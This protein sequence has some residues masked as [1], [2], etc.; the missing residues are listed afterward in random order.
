MIGRYIARR[1]IQAVPTLLGITVLAYTIM[2]LA[3]GDPLL[4]FED[5]RGVT[6]EQLASLRQAYGFDRPLPIQYLDWLSR[7][8]RLDFGRSF[9]THLPARDLIFERMPATL[10]LTLSALAV[11]I[12]VGIPAGVWAAVW[13]GRWPDQLVR[14]VAV[15]GDAVPH[16][17]LGLIALAI[18]AVQLRWLPTGGILTLGADPLDIGD[19]LRHL[20][21]PAV[22]LGTGSLAI[23]AR[24]MRTEMLDVLGQDY[25]RTARAKG[26]PQRLVLYGHALRNAMIPAVTVLGGLL[27]TLLA[28]AAT[29]EYVFSWPGMGRLA[30]D[31]AVSRDYPVVMGLVLIAAVLI[32]VGNLLSDILYGVIDPRIRLE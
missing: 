22:V 13:R 19:R 31:A 27:P 16:F 5:S 20:L 28:G 30:V 18:L 10:E 3:P 1:L 14:V 21:L 9:T 29:T 12:A 15:M 6:A 11:G 23:F 32:L 25:V 24:Y 2:R 7:A 26:L 4:V 17:W 8:A